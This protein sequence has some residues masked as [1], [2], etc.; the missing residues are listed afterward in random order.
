MSVSYAYWKQA[1][2]PFTENINSCS[3]NAAEKGSRIELFLNATLMSMHK[4]LPLKQFWM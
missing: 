4:N 1:F 2:N 3:H